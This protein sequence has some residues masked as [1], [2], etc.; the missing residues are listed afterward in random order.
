MRIS[1][2]GHATHAEIQYPCELVATDWRG[3]VPVGGGGPRRQPDARHHPR[4][5]RPHARSSTINGRCSRSSTPRVRSATARTG[6]RAA[7]R[8]RR[9]ATCS[10]ADGAA[11]PC[12]PATAPA[13]CWS[14]GS[15][16]RP[17]RRCRRTRSL[18]TRRRSR[19]FVSGSIRAL[20]PRRRRRRPLLRGRRRWRSID[21]RLRRS[22][23]ARGRRRSIAS[24]RHISAS[25][26]RWN[27]RRSPTRCS[28]GAST[29]MS[30]ASS[31]ARKT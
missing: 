5:R 29:S 19:S 30:G 10:K 6:E 18:S 24:S 25:G 14:I 17:N 31:R 23:G 15:W 13:A 27:R 22:A 4:V 12:G 20:A 2:A 11:P 8:S 28:S 21:R 9:M 7:S 3:R 16:A 26:G 1:Y